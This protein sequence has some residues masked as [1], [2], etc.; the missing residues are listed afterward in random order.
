MGFIDKLNEQI[1]H[2]FAAS[3]QYVAIAVHYDAETLPRLAA[4]FYQQAV[5]ERNHALMLVLNVFKDGLRTAPWAL[6]DLRRI[7]R[8]ERFDV[9]TLVDRAKAGRV[10]SA[11]WII[12]NWLA[13]TQGAPGWKAVSERIGRHPPSMRAAGTYAL[14]RR[15]GSPRR[16][17]HFVVPSVNDDM[18]RC[19]VGLGYATAGLARGW[20]PVPMPASAGRHPR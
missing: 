6:E 1:G 3:Q 18:W 16:V 12:A 20:R 19:A 13:E 7:V 8:H 5:E 15:I 4:T 10:A 2:E 14:W 9:Q 11:L 17:G